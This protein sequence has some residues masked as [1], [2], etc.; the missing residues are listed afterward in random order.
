MRIPR[1]FRP[2][3]A[4]GAL[5]AALF[6]LGLGRARAEGQAAGQPAPAPK[7]T[8]APR[9]AATPAP[10]PVPGSPEAKAREEQLRF[11]ALGMGMIAKMPDEGPAPTEDDL[12]F[13]DPAT[14]QRLI[15]ILKDPTVYEKGGRLFSTIAGSRQNDPGQPIVRQDEKYYYLVAPERVESPKDETAAAAEGLNQIVKVSEVEGEVVAPPLVQRPAVRFEE[16]SEGLPTT[17]MWR[18]NL[19]L[20][21]FEKDGKKEIVVPNPRMGGLGLSIFKLEGKAWKKL[22]VTVDLGGGQQD[23]DYGGVD[24]ADVDG[25]GKLD[26]AYIG[27]GSGPRI[28]YNAGGWKFQS[29][30]DGMP[31][32]FSGRTVLLGDFDGD[33]KVDVVAIADEDNW[34]NIE[35]RDE[36]GRPALPKPENGWVVGYNVRSFVRKAGG[37]FEELHDGFEPGC[38]AMAGGLQVHPKDKGAPFLVTGCHYVGW[39]TVVFEYDR[40]AKRWRGVARDPVAEQWALHSG[41]TVGT[42]QGKPAAYVGWWKG[43]PQGAA[44]PMKGYGVSAYYRDGKGWKRSRVFKTVGPGAAPKAVAVGDLDGDGLDDVAVADDEQ[45]R[46]RVFLQRKGGGFDELALAEP[47]AYLNYGTSLKIGDVDGDGRN[48]IVLMHQYGTGTKTRAGGVQVFVRR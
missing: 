37:K 9:P 2:S 21:D 28:L 23:L 6:L 46:V 18:E 17:G 3:I 14:G 19:T 48:D 47:L 25:D 42:Y 40:K 20:A 27:H 26:V 36:A 5:L 22:P 39:D 7:P 33:G 34:K 10:T 32:R 1:A 35:Q 45:H 16:L 38:Y 24:V 13:V 44:P 15:K 4:A 43:G 29:R 31:K 11:D 12:I 30:D 41:A 8:A